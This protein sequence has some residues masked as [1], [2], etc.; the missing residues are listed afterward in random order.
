MI[1]DESVAQKRLALSSF[2]G[3]DREKQVR[4]RSFSA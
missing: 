4:F 2:V 3:K 1:N